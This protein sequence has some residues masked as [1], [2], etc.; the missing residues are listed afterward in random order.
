LASVL[1]AHFDAG[2]TERI[3]EHLK[4]VVNEDVDMVHAFEMCVACD[5]RF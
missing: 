5:K 1:A 3:R 2:L 4:R